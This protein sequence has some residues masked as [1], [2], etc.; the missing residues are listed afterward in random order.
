VGNAVDNEGN[1]IGHGVVDIASGVADE[2][3]NGINRVAGNLNNGANRIIG[4]LT[5]SRRPEGFFDDVLDI[6]KKAIDCAN[7]MFSLAVLPISVLNPA[8]GAALGTI[9]PVLQQAAKA[10]SAFENI[11]DKASA[12][13]D[14]LRRLAQAVILRNVLAD[15]YLATLMARP[16]PELKTEGLFDDFVK[17]VDSTM[18]T[19]GIGMV[20]VVVQAVPVLEPI[21]AYTLPLLGG[22]SDA[23]EVARR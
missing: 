22:L 3:G 6:G 18:M 19:I 15:K 11:Q 13:F 2:A 23:A 10:E 12:I 20:G 17:S 16:V 1:R 8:L 21:V 14:D 4:N 7:P 5:G 9:L